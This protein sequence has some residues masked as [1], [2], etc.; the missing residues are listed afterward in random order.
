M[1]GNLQNTMQL[2]QKLKFIQ[3]CSENIKMHFI[4]NITVLF[5]VQKFLVCVNGNMKTTSIYRLA[6]RYYSQ[7]TALAQIIIVFKLCP[8]KWQT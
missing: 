2:R 1:N 3:K 7:T 8:A 6:G 4:H 5:C